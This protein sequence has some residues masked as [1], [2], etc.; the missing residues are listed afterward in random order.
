MVILPGYHKILRLCII[1]LSLFGCK[2]LNYHDIV[3]GDLT[4]PSSSLFLEDIWYQGR[5]YVTTNRSDL[6]ATYDAFE[7][8][9]DSYRPPPEALEGNSEEAKCIYIDIFGKHSTEADL[10]E[11]PWRLQKSF[12]TR[13]ANRIWLLLES[14]PSE[15]MSLNRYSLL[16]KEGNL[17]LPIVLAR[18]F[19][20]N[21]VNE[22]QTW[23][24]DYEF[25]LSRMRQQKGHEGS[26]NW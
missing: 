26:K 1:S 5:I 13:F 24:G 21:L 12:G 2:P 20:L 6:Q 15:K 23:G 11:S 14:L 7:G 4:E 19:H 22:F 9:P 25:N 18:D 10:P 17:Y 16:Q 8:L 3:L